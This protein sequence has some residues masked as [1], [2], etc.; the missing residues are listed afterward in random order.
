MS[1]IIICKANCLIYNNNCHIERL[2]DIL[3]EFTGYFLISK[4]SISLKP[5][6]YDDSRNA[7]KTSNKYKF[8]NFRILAAWLKSVFSIKKK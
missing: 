7:I 2:K 5:D 4:Y 3:L 8:I 1:V 6:L